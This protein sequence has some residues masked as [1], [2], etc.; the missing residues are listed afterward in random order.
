ML[1]IEE[2]DPQRPRVLLSHIPLWRSQTLSCG[3]LRTRTKQISEKQGYS[4][5]CM[6]PQGV[7]EYLLDAVKPVYVF[8]GDDHDHCTVSHIRNA[9]EAKLGGAS[10]QKRQEVNLITKDTM[11]SKE[12]KIVEQTLGTFSFLQ[13]N[14]QPSFGLLSLFHSYQCNTQTQ[15]GGLEEERCTSYPSGLATRVCFTPPQ[16]YIYLWYAL[17]TVLSMVAILVEGCWLRPTA[18]SADSPNSMMM[19]TTAAATAIAKQN[20]RRAAVEV[21]ALACF[22]FSLHLFFVFKDL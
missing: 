11:Q 10:R 3:P 12:A 16:L 2:G 1:F 4:Y 14:P 15:E 7:S 6:L 9:Q 21:C 13:G 20:R 17:L 18:A 19:R 22:A 5:K 8:S